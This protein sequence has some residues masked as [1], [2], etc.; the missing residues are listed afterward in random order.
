MHEELTQ[1]SPKWQG[2]LLL[3]I[4]LWRHGIYYERLRLGF[5]RCQD[6][7]VCCAL[8]PIE[9]FCEHG[10]AT[11]VG[12]L[13]YENRRLSTESRVVVRCVPCWILVCLYYTLY[14]V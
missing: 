7:L 9:P 10:R 5:L 12:C 14:V 3:R 13:S 1:W 6:P 2:W 11:R 4:G 8:C